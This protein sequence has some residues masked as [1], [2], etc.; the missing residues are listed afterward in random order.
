MDAEDERRQARASA[1]RAEAVQEQL[2]SS[3]D[4]AKASVA[5]IPLPRSA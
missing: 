4:A 2:L 3:I 1:E 5:P